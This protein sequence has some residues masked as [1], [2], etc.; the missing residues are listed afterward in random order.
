MKTFRFTIPDPPLS[1]KE[2]EGRYKGV[3]KEIGQ[4]ILWGWM[5]LL[6]LFWIFRFWTLKEETLWLLSLDVYRGDA[7][8]DLVTVSLARDGLMFL[9]GGSIQL[10][11]YFLIVRRH[12]RGEK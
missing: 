5:L 3:Q 10:L 8:I 1:K 12:F 11:G 2:Q 6:G 7:S 4:P 9:L